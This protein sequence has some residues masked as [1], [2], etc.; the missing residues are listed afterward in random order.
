ML[1]P[2]HFRFVLLKDQFST[3]LANVQMHLF[4]AFDFEQYPSFP[5]HYDLGD[6]CHLNHSLKATGHFLCPDMKEFDPDIVDG[7]RKWPNIHLVRL[8]GVVLLPGIPYKF[9]CKPFRDRVKR[10]LPPPMDEDLLSC[11][12]Q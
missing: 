1:E 6:F 7:I 5:S 10:Y 2:R 12:I 4:A 11:I 3:I 9:C 8:A